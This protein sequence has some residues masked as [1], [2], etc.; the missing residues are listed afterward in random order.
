MTTAGKIPKSP[1]GDRRADQAVQPV[2][3]PVKPAPARMGKF[4]CIL[5]QRRPV[6]GVTARL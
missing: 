2:H 1:K 4:G 5:R 6:I 3:Q